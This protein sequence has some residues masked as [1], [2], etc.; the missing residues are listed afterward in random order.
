MHV[1]ARVKRKFNEDESKGIFYL[2]RLVIDPISEHLH[3]CMCTCFQCPFAPA[4]LL[5]PYFH[6][7]DTRDVGVLSLPD[8]V[9][10]VCALLPDT[11]AQ[12][13]ASQ[14]SFFL[15]DNNYTSIIKL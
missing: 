8:F 10:G 1:L 9:L 15:L 14:Q 13:F 11:R 7:I 12:V 2:L 6:A 5:R 3:T 4:A